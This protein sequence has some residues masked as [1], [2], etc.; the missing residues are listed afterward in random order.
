MRVRHKSRSNIESHTILS[1][2]Y[3]QANKTNTHCPLWLTVNDPFAK[4]SVYVGPLFRTPVMPTSTCT[5]HFH[6]GYPI[7]ARGP[8]RGPSIV[9]RAARIPKTVCHRAPKHLPFPCFSATTLSLYRR[10]FIST[11]N[12]PRHPWSARPK[13]VRRPRSYRDLLLGHFAVTKPAIRKCVCVPARQI[14]MMG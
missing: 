8:P 13:Y 12:V 1:L 3:P 10:M 9:S 14:I 6:V 2:D 5:C 7:R 11:P 4:P